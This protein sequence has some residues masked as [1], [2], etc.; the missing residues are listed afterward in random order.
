MWVSPEEKLD[1]LNR[2]GSR[3]QELVAQIDALP[4]SPARLLFQECLESVLAFYGHG[5]ERILQLVANAGPDGQKIYHDLVHDNVVRG[6]LI[7]HDLHPVAIET[8]LRDALDKVR[9]YL[10]SHGG[11]VELISLTNDV[12]RLRLQGTCKSCASSTVTLELAIRHAIEEACPDLVGFEVEGAPAQSTGATVIPDAQRVTPDWVVIDNALQLD[13]EAGMSVRVGDLRLVICKVNGDLYA[14]RNN[15]P[16]CNMPLNTRMLDS[17]LLQCGLGHQY[18][19]RQ[20]G[21]CP[22]N[23]NVHLD[24]FPLLILDDVVK[25]AVVSEASR[26]AS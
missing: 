5:L 23:P 25:V 26:F 7:I 20:A 1:A 4:N 2:A 3:I 21:R 19:V 12:A 14:Y 15:C 24:P 22:D 10:R 8:R 16:T 18:D 17:G 13:D 6:L 11:N 9:P